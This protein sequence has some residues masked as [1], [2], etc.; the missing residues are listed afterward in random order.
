M[1]RG[2]FREVGED[3]Q[4]MLEE[5]SSVIREENIQSLN[6]TL[7]QENN[8]GDKIFNSFFTQSTWS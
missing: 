6:I 5:F 2:G 3:S 8:P 4:S 1:W 7:L